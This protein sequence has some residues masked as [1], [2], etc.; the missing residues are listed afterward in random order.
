M[1]AEAGLL[2]TYLSALKNTMHG[3]KLTPCLPQMHGM[4]YK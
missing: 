3:P 1:A 4:F 2:R